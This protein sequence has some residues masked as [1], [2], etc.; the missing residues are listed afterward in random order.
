MSPFL[1]H[2]DEIF[3]TA[4]EA[5]PDAGELSILVGRD[6]IIHMVAGTEWALEPLRLHYGAKAAYHISRGP[7]GIRLEARSASETCVL[8]SQSPG[9]RLPLLPPDCP[10]YH[11]L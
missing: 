3:S 6:G 5:G 4:Q 1:Q 10:Q 7:Q 8:Q 2:A 11:T 9:R